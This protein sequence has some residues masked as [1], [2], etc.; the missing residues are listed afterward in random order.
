[1]AGEVQIRA[2]LEIAPGLNAALIS[3]CIFLYA[4][5]VGPKTAGVVGLFCTACFGR[6]DSDVDYCRHQRDSGD[7]PT[8][9]Y[10]ARADTTVHYGNEPATGGERAS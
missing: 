9:D 5:T 4:E 7:G 10:K 2:T 8:S 6:M 3:A 1:M